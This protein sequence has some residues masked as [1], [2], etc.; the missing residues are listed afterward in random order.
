MIWRVAEFALW[1][2]LAWASGVYS[3]IQHDKQLEL[4]KFFVVISII[5]MI[6]MFRAFFLGIKFIT[7]K[8]VC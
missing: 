8:E 1:T 7:K 3:A 5:S 6:M 4:P 2:S